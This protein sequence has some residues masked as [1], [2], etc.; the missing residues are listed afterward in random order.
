VAK[1]VEEFR[2]R[3]IARLAVLGQKERLLQGDTIWLCA[4]CYTCYERCPEKVRVSEIV[5]ALRNIAVKDGIIHPTY[6]SLMK[7]IAEKGYIYEIDEFE[8]EM[9]DDEGLPEAPVP[10]QEEIKLIL[11][12]TGFIE[13]VE[14]SR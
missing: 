6:K 5:A 10:A 11:E 7:S 9:R 12:K 3:R 1:R 2:P 4:G 13:R 14:G 8:N